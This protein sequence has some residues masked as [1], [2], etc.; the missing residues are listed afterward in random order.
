MEILWKL[1][2]VW[3]M[4]GNNMEIAWNGREI[5]RNWPPY[6]SPVIR[7]QVNARLEGSIH[8]TCMKRVYAQLT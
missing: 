6:L 5:Y 8:D 2:T 3:K 7:K 4:C 1:E